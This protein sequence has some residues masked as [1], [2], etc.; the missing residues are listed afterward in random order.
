MILGTKMQYTITGTRNNFEK[1]VIGLALD[2]YLNKLMSKRLINHLSVN[3]KLSKKLDDNA[4][5]YCDVD[6]YN[7]NNKPREFNIELNKN[8]SFR[9]ILMTLAHEC[10]H[11]KQYALSEINDSLTHWKGVR[12]SSQMDYWDSPWEI[13]ARGREAG[14][15]TRFVQH[16]GFSFPKTI[17]ERD[18]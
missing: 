18:N 14:L 10:V 12:V 11:L 6:G 3:V 5:G 17:D 1:K 4:D 2:Y 13:E 7:T 8:K 9:Y 15:Y 16:Y